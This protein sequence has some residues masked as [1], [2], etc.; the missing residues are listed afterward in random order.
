MAA[1][2]KVKKTK[3]PRY[4]E[5]VVLGQHSLLLLLT[6]KLMRKI[7]DAAKKRRE[8]QMASAV[9][10]LPAEILLAHNIVAT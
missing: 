8:K 3:M 7:A 9:R 10:F 6:L 4:I 5:V 2:D 1:K